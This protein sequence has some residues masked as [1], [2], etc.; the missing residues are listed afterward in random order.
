M[1]KGIPKKDYHHEYN[2]K[3]KERLLEKILKPVTCECGMEMAVCNLKRHQKSRNHIK[4]MKTL[5]ESIF[6][7]IV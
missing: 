2:L 1:I 4:K 5:G 7:S 3:N 6:E